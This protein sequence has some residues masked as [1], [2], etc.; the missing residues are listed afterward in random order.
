M[1]LFL[2]KIIA[3][4]T[5]ECQCDWQVTLYQSWEVVFK[6]WLSQFTT[7]YKLYLRVCRVGIGVLVLIIELL[8]IR[9]IIRV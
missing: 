1:A 5:R 9:V 3:V 2:I 6:P 4:E 8:I 7:I